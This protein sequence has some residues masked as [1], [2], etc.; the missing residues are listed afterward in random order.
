MSFSINIC[1]KLFILVFLLSGLNSLA[2]A[3]DFVVYFTVGKA[4]KIIRDKII[5]LKKRDNLYLSDK[6]DIEKN[7]QVIL[8]CKNGNVIKLNDSGTQ[9]LSDAASQCSKQARS[10]TYA[11][12][13]FIYDEFTG[14]DTK[15]DEKNYLNNLGA[16]SRGW[17]VL[18]ISPDTINYC[19][20]DIKIGWRDRTYAGT[21]TVFADSQA[22]Q[23]L[24]KIN[25]THNTFKLSSLTAG[26]KFPGVYFWNISSS[27]HQTSPMYFI[28]ITGHTDYEK[29]ITSIL[30]NV[31]QT[32]PAETAYMSGFLLEENHLLVE[33]AKYYKKAYLLEP[34][35]LIYKNTKL[36]FYE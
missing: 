7:A 19:N 11:Y 12:F 32:T 26:L 1:R 16:V 14:A 20:G 29:N 21:A 31:I 8:I 30:Q 15:I 27:I 36:R 13:H 25:Y 3:P 18:N 17:P 35:N 6:L 4:N 24:K 34:E 23:P 10:F 9:N 28:K 5:P 22:S 33:A 2:Q